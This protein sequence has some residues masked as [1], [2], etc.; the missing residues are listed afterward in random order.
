[1]PD[2]KL[3]RISELNIERSMTEIT[4]IKNIKSYLRVVYGHPT[5]SYK[6][7]LL[8]WKQSPQA[9][10]IAGREAIEKAGLTITDETPRI[11]LLYPTFRLEKEGKIR[12]I[13]GKPQMEALTEAEVYEVEPEYSSDYQAVIGYDLGSIEGYAPK[14]ILRRELFNRIKL[15]SGGFTV[16]DADESKLSG[17]ERGYL[18]FDE[19]RFYL[20]R[21]ISNDM[22]DR[23]L[24]SLYVQ[25]ELADRRGDPM[26]DLLVSLVT[27]CLY[28]YFGLLKAE[29]D[30]LNVYAVTMQ[31]MSE[32]V[33]RDFL[34]ELSSL[35]T[36]M[37]LDLSENIL[38]FDEI[39]IA[40][41]LLRT[42]AFEDMHVTFWGVMQ[43]VSDADLREEIAI[44]DEKLHKTVDGYLGKLNDAVK[45]GSLLTYPN[46]PLD[47]ELNLE[48]LKGE[49][50]KDVNN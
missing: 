5:L 24:I 29:D 34:R 46:Y 38:T 47:Y 39:A 17:S 3:K 50:P 9:K 8:V 13:D 2:E 33:L 43:N 1:M 11:V 32:E 20:K 49:K 25:E 10:E 31:R 40:N 45:S 7:H 35:S 22:Q 48:L 41:A 42:D 15:A 19:R 21:G 16:K 30:S 26:G 14:P 37:M 18:D 36:E 28:G 44:F 12:E 23:T 27:Y 6:N 4:D